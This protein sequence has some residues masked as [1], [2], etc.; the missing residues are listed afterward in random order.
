MRGGIGHGIAC[1]KNFLVEWKAVQAEMPLKLWSPES[2]E[3]EQ[4]GMGAAST[5]AAGSCQ[6]SV[7][8]S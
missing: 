7:F 4:Y 1:N 2:S 6:N 3:L 5:P 8:V